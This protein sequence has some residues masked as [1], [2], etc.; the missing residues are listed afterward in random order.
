MKQFK[1][2]VIGVIAGVSLTALAQT[3]FFNEAG[4]VKESKTAWCVDVCTKQ[5]AANAI[6][7]HFK[8]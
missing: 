5:D 4:Q 7:A 8:K 2:L 1:L 3:G 6:S